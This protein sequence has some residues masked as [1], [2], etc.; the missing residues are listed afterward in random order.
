MK[1]NPTKCNF[2]CIVVQ[3]MIGTNNGYLL[4]ALFV[5]IVGVPMIGTNKPYHFLLAIQWKFTTFISTYVNAF[6]YKYTE[7]KMPFHVGGTRPNKI[8]YFMRGWTCTFPCFVPILGGGLPLLI[9]RL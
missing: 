4:G 8:C 9:A 3:L 6:G 5:P 7:G 1:A 2:G